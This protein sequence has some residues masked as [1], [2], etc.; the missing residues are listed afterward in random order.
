[1]LDFG[2]HTPL[3]DDATI[4]IAP[5]NNIFLKK[6]YHGWM[7][8]VISN[9]KDN[10]SYNGG[11]FLSKSYIIKFLNIMYQKITENRYQWKVPTFLHSY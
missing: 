10:G 2:C 7:C 8:M 9:G 5:L 6:K 4:L 11:V 3:S 1:M